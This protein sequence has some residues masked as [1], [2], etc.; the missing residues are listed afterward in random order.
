MSVRDTLPTGIVAD[1]FYREHATSPG[2]PECPDRF[3]AARVGSLDGVSGS[4]R[5]DIPSRK[6]TRSELLLC[7]TEAYVQSVDEDVS[8]GRPTLRTGDTDIGSASFEVA[9]RA[10]GGVL[11]AVDS[12]LKQE[13]KN[14]FCILRPPGHHAESDR[15]MGF[16]IFNNAAIAARY[17]M[18]HEG[19][20]R[21]LIADW[22]VH[23]GNGTQWIFYDDPSVFY[24]STHQWPHFPGTGKRNDIGTRAGLGF[25]RNAPLSAG[26][27]RQEVLGAF[28]D[29]LVPAMR[30]F[31]PQF[32]ILSAG[33]DCEAGD[34]M[35]GFCLQE[36]DFI[37]LTEIMLEIADTHAQG[38]LVSV[39]EGGYRLKGLTQLC[40]AHV[41]TLAASG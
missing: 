39:L 6:A 24:F 11:N 32:V 37:E 4:A 18:Q 15:G 35:G 19:V 8:M 22:D 21:V 2:H 28:R 25:T 14:A 29:V 3:D 12:V 33:F 30:T 20:D 17:A 13:T 10:V 5:L 23:H 31:K 41:A 9:S 16:C 34:P 26:S 1:A 27:G 7:H 36:Q 38:R 40:R